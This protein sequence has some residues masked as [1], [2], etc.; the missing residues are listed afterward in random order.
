[1]TSPGSHH[2]YAWGNIPLGY[3]EFGMNPVGAVRLTTR[4]GESAYVSV[5]PPVPCPT[6]AAFELRTVSADGPSAAELHDWLSSTTA[7]VVDR[8]ARQRALDAEPVHLQE[9]LALGEAKLRIQDAIN[10]R[11]NRH[12]ALVEE[13]SV[14]Q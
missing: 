8:N 7:V 3:T 9:H 1:V 11:N 2:F 13:T 12:V 6:R 10:E 14:A 4:P 5:E